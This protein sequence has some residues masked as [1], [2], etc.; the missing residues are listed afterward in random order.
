MKDIKKVINKVAILSIKPEF[1][2][3]ILLHNKTIELRK[4]TFGLKRNDIIIVYTSAPNQSIEFWFRIKKIE[5]SSV[6]DIWNKY[7]DKL[8]IN[9]EEYL[10]YFN[11][12]KEATCFHIGDLNPLDPVIP[13]SRIQQL[14]PDFIPPQ[15][16]IWIDNNMGRFAKLLNA[17][18]PSLPHNAFPQLSL[19]KYE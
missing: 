3:K 15:G 1:A 19:F 14:V 10:A 13:L 12:C 16:I 4:S 9:H 11:G 2:S 7:D 5:V 8:G 17:L 18:S 6:E